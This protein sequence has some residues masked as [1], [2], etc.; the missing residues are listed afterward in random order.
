MQ[1]TLGKVLVLLTTAL[2]WSLAIWIYGAYTQSIDWGWKEP[3]KDVEKKRIPS[4]MDARKKEVETATAGA[5][6][7]QAAVQS[8]RKTLHDDRI[9]YPRNHLFYNTVRNYVTSAP[10]KIEVKEI[11][12]NPNGSLVL[13]PPSPVGMPVFERPVSGLT[14]SEEGLHQ[15]LRDLQGQIDVEVATLKKLDQE[16]KTITLRLSPLKDAEG[17]ILRKGLPD[18]D[19]VESQAQVKLR[20]EI[21]RIRPLW[22]RELANAQLLLDRRESLRRRLEELQQKRKVASAAP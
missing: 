21:E 22:T 18:L 5:A 7:A 1:T 8:A 4:E 6:R 12:L 10:G 11:K 9:Q 19:E 20:E 2:S 16:Q 14:R 15:E 3:R 17:K 13:A